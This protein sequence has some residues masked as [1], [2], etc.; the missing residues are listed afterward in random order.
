MRRF[1]TVMLLFLL[2]APPARAAT[3]YYVA[4]T[5][6]DS[7][8]CAQAQSTATPKLT[9]GAI[10]SAGC[11][12][13]GDTLYI[14]TGTY[15]EKIDSTTQTLPT[16]TSWA[17]PITIASYPAETAII[18][19]T[20]G[21]TVI[22]LAFETAAALKKYYIFDR[23][24]ID[25][26]NSTNT[27]ISQYAVNTSTSVLVPGGGFIR[28][29]NCVVT[30]GPDNLV[31]WGRGSNSNEIIGSH[32]HTNHEAAVGTRLDGHGVY[33]ESSNNLVERNE[34]DTITGYGV[35]VY[36]GYSPA[37]RA[38]NNT[39]QYNVVHGTGT[40]GGGANSA[41]ILLGSGDGNLAYR[42]ILY[43]QNN[44]IIVGFNA[45][46]T[47]KVYHNTVYGHTNDG[48]QIQASSSSVNLS[49][50]IAYSNGTNIHNLAASGTTYATNL[51]NIAGTGC[52]ITNATVGNVMIAAGS[53]DF[54]LV[55]TSPA[56]N[57]GTVL[58][59]FV[60][61]N[62]PDIGAHETFGV[63]TATIVD[64][65]TD[66]LMQIN[67][68]SDQAPPLLP[69]TGCTGFSATK[70]GSPNIITSCARTGTSQITLTLTDA[71]T[72]ATPAA[73]TYTTGTATPVTDSALIGNL[74]KQRLNAVGS[75]SAAVAHLG[76]SAPV[77]TQVAYRFE[78][79]GG[80]EAAPDCTRALNTGITIPPNSC[81]RV[82]AQVSN[83]VAD[84]GASGYTVYSQKN[85]SGGYA[86]I[87]NG[88]CTSTGI[89]FASGTG[90][91]PPELL[92]GSTTEQLAGAGT[93]TAG[94][95]MLSMSE[96]PS[97]TLTTGL[98]T[99]L[100]P[101]LCVGSGNSAG[102]YFELH[103][104][105]PPSGTALDTYTQTPKITIGGYDARSGAR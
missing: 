103:V 42:N 12:T 20:S 52:A 83:S 82:R 14:R 15:A 3:T 33:I 31:F 43:G 11:L 10:F 102:D 101:A 61:N 8:S 105:R 87:P 57:A 19:P 84:F 48:I 40:Y 34:I 64:G 39:V 75:T 74:Y 16:G 77:L 96:V 35:H 78:C 50:N 95:S 66:N 60:S 47:T 81:V 63:A 62:A 104:V 9:I 51:C 13:A 79:Y 76:G 41:G 25:G 55:A 80:T 88:P 2:S 67:F 94:G 70:S 65:V 4:K 56:V 45:S 29:T 89:C 68:T 69:L 99:E 38:N 30:G 100:L 54:G 18:K 97:V 49:N 71:Y 27:V 23:L 21:D 91:L 72:S 93:F 1:L 24:T 7:N 17:S 92:T 26:T 53:Q 28:Y 6:S 58:S 36:D 44:G 90:T 37:V 59:G 98:D 85:G 22:R 5:G 73:F 86:A 32:I 46:T